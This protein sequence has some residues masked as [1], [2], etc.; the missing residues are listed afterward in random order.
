MLIRKTL[1]LHPGQDRK[2]EE[3]HGLSANMQIRKIIPENLRFPGPAF[4][5]LEKR[6]PAELG[7][8]R[9]PLSSSAL[10]AS[11]MV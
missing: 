11:N 6:E 3:R 7:P 2:E 10:F 9:G 1:F 5:S 4:S 8:Q